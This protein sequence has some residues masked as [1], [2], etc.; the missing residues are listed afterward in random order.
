MGVSGLCNLGLQQFSFLH[1]LLLYVMIAHTLNMCAPYILCTFDNILGLLNL[2]IIAS[3]PPLECLHWM[4]RVH[5]FIFKLCIM[6]VQTL[7]MCTDDTGP[8][9]SLVLF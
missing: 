2:D 6:I 1:I 8:E 3:T 9:Q 5:S 7:N 4:N